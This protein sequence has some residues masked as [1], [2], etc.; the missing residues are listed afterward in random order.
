MGSLARYFKLECVLLSER[1]I[2]MRRSAIMR[3]LQV[4]S[5]A[6]LLDLM[7]TH[8]ILTDINDTKQNRIRN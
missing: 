2:E 3:K 7:I 8:R 5:V 4:S 6:E 1:A